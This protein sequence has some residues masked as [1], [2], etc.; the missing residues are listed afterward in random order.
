MRTVKTTKEMGNK[1][2]CCIS[3]SPKAPRKKVEEIYAPED[4]VVEPPPPQRLA[5]SSNLQHISE[6]EPD[7]ESSS[8]DCQADCWP[9][10]LG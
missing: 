2:S 6:R 1:Q 5:S 10:I 7:G 3:A 9:F 8:P 4:H